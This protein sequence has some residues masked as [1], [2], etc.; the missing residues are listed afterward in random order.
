[1]YTELQHINLVLQ[2]NGSLGILAPVLMGE[3]MLTFSNAV[4][5]LGGFIPFVSGLKSRFK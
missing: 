2:V 1:M 3:I 5:N 4:F